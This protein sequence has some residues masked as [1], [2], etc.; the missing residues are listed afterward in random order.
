MTDPTRAA[1]E[2]ALHKLNELSERLAIGRQ[3]D[4]TCTASSTP[5]KM[6]PSPHARSMQKPAKKISCVSGA[7][8]RG[9]GWGQ[10]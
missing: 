10:A 1:Y 5:H 3:D 4:G 9:H 8:F 6:L 2:S 7:L